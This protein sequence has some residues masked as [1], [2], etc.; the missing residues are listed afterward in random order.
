MKK[1][2][3]ATG[4]E[5]SR[6]MPQDLQNVM[7]ALKDSPLDGVVLGLYVKGGP[8]NTPCTSTTVTVGRKWSKDWFSADVAALK[9]AKSRTLTDNFLMAWI[10][11]TET[12]PGTSAL[13]IQW[14]DDARWAT[15]ANNLG[16]LAWVA[17]Q[18]GLKGL[19][20][21]SEDYGSSGQFAFQA[22]D[23][24]Y[25][26]TA[27]LARARGAQV[28]R[29]MGKEYP[30][31][32]LL[33]YWLLSIDFRESMASQPGTVL[34]ARG[35]L[36]VPFVNGMLDA[37]PP[38][39]K[40]IDGTESAYMYTGQ[41]FAG[42][43]A[44]I[45]VACQSLVVPENRAKYRN[46]VQTGFGIYLDAHVNPSTSPWYQGPLDGSRTA[47]LRRNVSDALAAADEYV[48]L[49]GE[50][51]CWNHWKFK[52]GGDYNGVQLWE[53]EMPG[54][55]TAIAFAKDSDAFGKRR[56]EAMRAAGELKNLAQNAGYEDPSGTAGSLPPGWGSWQVEG[57]K[58]TFTLDR[59]TGRQSQSSAKAAGV[60]D[61]CF[62]QSYPVKPGELYGVEAMSLNK[63]NSTTSI[64]VRWQDSDGKWNNE[65]NDHLIYFP[66]STG[67]SKAFG[68]VT[69]PQGAGRMVVLLGMRQPSPQDECWYDN[70]AVYGLE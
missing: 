61:G 14:D 68:T 3:I 23:G 5:F 46:Q 34:K 60:R 43:T 69:V 29:A 25:D 33:A 66:Q 24:S 48:W 1:K 28:V 10:S 27:V 2:L 58:G 40:L 38:A 57:S 50:K 51:G 36:W 17:K 62:I 64:M 37:L 9:S 35:D 8:L 31:I 11:P 20:L 15:L 52:A 21:D 19:I 55:G 18:G 53:E 49:Y 16:V 13:R 41:D 6:L 30:D 42:A 67:W 22:S 45:K 56:M 4:W 39:A 44:K 54:F 65:S 7:S 70:I 63:G 12:S 26:A 32:T 47:R 59:S